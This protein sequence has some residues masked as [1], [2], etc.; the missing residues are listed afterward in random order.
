LELELVLTDSLV[1]G[2]GELSTVGVVE[3]A[4]AGATGAGSTAGWE[5]VG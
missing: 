5:D 4:G 3:G 1:L 2:A